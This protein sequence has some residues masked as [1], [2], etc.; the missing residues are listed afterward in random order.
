MLANTADAYESVYRSAQQVGDRATQLGLPEIAF[1]G[2]V[3]A[4][5]ATFFHSK[6]AEGNQRHGELLAQTLVAV[7]DALARLRHASSSTWAERLISLTA[8]AVEAATS[9]YFLVQED[10]ESALAQLTPRVERSIPADF[11]YSVEQIGNWGKS[12]STARALAH[13]SYSHGNAAIASA[14][15][16][17]AAQRAAEEQA[18]E[19]TVAVINDRYR[20]ERSADASPQRLRQLRDEAWALAQDVRASYRSRSGRIWASYVADTLFGTMVK[21]ELGDQTSTAES[22]F[23]RIESMK[24]RMLLDRLANPGTREVDTH[25]ALEL[26]REVLSF[27]SP[28]LEDISLTF[29]EMRLVSQLSGFQSVGARD[30]SR[31]EALAELETLYRDTETGY[32]QPAAPIPLETLRETLAPDEALLEY[33]IPYNALHPASELWLILITRDEIHRTRVDLDQVLQK[34]SG[35]TGRMSIDGQ[36]PV[37]SSALGNLIVTLR[38]HIRSADEKQAKRLLRGLYRLLITPL[39]SLGFRPESYGRLV[40]V[41]HGALHYIPFAALLDDKDRF[42]IEHAEVV[43]APSASIWQFLTKRAGAG[44]QF[45]ALGNPDLTSRGVADLPFAD[46]EISEIRKILTLPQRIYQAGDATKARLISG[47]EDVGILHLSTHGEFPDHNAA[48]EHAIWLADDAGMSAAL[49]AAEVR[50]LL[51]QQARLV[52]LSVCNG[53]LYRIG[54]ADEPYGLLP[55]FLEA[56]TQNVI[57]TLWPLDDQFGRDFMIEL[58]R[59]LDQGVAAAMRKASLRFI[60]EDEYLRRWA[61]FVLV[62]SGR[63]NTARR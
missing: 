63:L 52:V 48:D 9:Q 39:E 8:A 14:R 35:F 51:L 37:D 50:K 13:L 61:A 12:I 32:G 33:F 1:R 16:A 5:D 55:A 15:L 4:A 45:V 2:A 36:A 30:E 24:A 62:G 41:P 44:S 29:E 27:E 28:G 19:L 54:P 59:H 22:V 60:N 42:L 57:G 47:A 56:G 46:Q 21:D 58:Y 25:N 20:G 17:I 6:L 34:P 43:M 18:A 26:E 49:S 3:L 38:T 10:I 11:A 31:G 53:G 23:A 40:I 7:A